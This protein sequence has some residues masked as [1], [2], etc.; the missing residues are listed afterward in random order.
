MSPIPTR[1]GSALTSRVCFV[2]KIDRRIDGGNSPYSNSL[3]GINQ[4]LKL[5]YGMEVVEK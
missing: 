1:L 4:C 2:I 3:F 5:C